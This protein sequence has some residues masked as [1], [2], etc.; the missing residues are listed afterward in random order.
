[1]QSSAECC[2]TQKQIQPSER[3]YWTAYWP[4]Q[5]TYPLHQSLTSPRQLEARVRARLKVRVPGQVTGSG[6]FLN[7]SRLGKVGG[8]LLFDLE[9]TSWQKN[10][11]RVTSVYLANVLSL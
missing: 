3:R 1:M 8:L 6:K 5:L 4:T 11:S 9:L 2:L 7:G 10:S